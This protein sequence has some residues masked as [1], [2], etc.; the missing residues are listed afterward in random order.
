MTDQND[1]DT[2]RPKPRRRRR[3]RR[4]ER[5]GPPEIADDHADADADG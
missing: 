1:P 3:R 4:R 5:S 2:Q